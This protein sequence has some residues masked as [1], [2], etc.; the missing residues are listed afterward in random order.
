[1][2]VLQH[3]V[4]QLKPY[5]SNE[6]NNLAPHIVLQC[7]NSIEGANGCTQLEHE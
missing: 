2:P 6:S 4:M 5:K 7:E 1:L 3:N